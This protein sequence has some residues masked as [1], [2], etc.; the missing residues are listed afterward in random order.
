MVIWC[1]QYLCTGQGGAYTFAGNWDY[2]RSAWKPHQHPLQRVLLTQ[3]LSRCDWE[4]PGLR[5]SYLAE[6]I[7]WQLKIKLAAMVT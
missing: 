7:S 2:W 4:V 3:Q 5:K 6:W 1:W